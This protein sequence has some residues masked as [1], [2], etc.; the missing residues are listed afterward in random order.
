MDRVLK[1][2]PAIPD[3]FFSVSNVAELLSAQVWVNCASPALVDVAP[4]KT[5]LSHA[6]L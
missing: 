3:S 6:I 4:S 5:L 2:L 1:S